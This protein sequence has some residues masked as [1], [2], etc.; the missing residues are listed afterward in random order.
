MGLP[1]W[2]A[3]SP[4]ESKDAIK[5]DLTASS[6]STIRRRVRSPVIPR[7]ARR[8]GN[9]HAPPSGTS[10]RSPRRGEFGFRIAPAFDFD[11]TERRLDPVE[12]DA[13]LP[14]VPESRNYTRGANDISTSRN[15]DHFRDYERSPWYFGLTDEPNPFSRPPHDLEDAPYYRAPRPPRAYGE[16]P[17][18]TPNFAPAGYAGPRHVPAAEML[19]SNTIRFPSRRPPMRPRSRDGEREAPLHLRNEIIIVEDGEEDDHE[20]VA[21][22]F[23]P[24]RRMGRRTIADGPLPSSSLRESWSP[25]STVDGLGDRERSFSPVEDHWDTMLST[26]APDPHLPS[27]DSSFTSAAASASFSASHPSSRSGSSNSNSASSSRTHLTIPSQSSRDEMIARACDTSDEDTASDTEPED[28]EVREISAP[29]HASSRNA[30]YLADEPPSR[31]PYRYSRDLRN[32]SRDAS[33]FVRNFY[34]FTSRAG[35]REG[36]LPNHSFDDD[37]SL[38]DRDAEDDAHIQDPELE[39]MRSILERLARRDDIPE[40]FW[41]SAGLTPPLAERVERLQRERL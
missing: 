22:G 4:E 5:V 21:V 37:I 24:L 30:N 28:I 38:G 16:L 41:I 26:V 10:Q 11:Y 6:R 1:V 9:A 35:P 39:Q 27:A 3:P 12:R 31:N 15:S 23:P 34:S 18:Y 19:E 13:P 33:R 25:A 14:P 40:E 20:H 32:R 36:S 8:S 17:A 7:R 2:R 29:R